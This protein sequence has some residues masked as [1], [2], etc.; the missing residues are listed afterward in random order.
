MAFFTQAY[1]DF[2]TELAANNHKDWFDVNRHRYELHVKKPLYAFIN[3]LI[4]TLARSNPSFLELQAKDCIFR[5]NRDIRF[6]SDKT[7]YKLRCSAVLAPNGKKGMLGEGFYIELGPEHL[8]LYGGVYELDKDQL[9]NFRLALLENLEVFQQAY[10]HPDFKQ[11]FG[12][13]Q[14]AK[15]KI[16]PKD[17]K[18]YI[19][20][21]PLLL[22]KQFYYYTTFSP[23]MILDDR[24]D[25]ILLNAYETAK[26]L[27][28]LFTQML[29]QNE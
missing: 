23:E 1:L 21:E 13:I 28:L 4:A 10:T 7:P 19:A 14:G 8:R 18:E 24:L 15:N 16:L 6:S 9:L 5:I 2:F 27:E 3:H 29:S 17:L 11:T 12:E 25:D 22:N 20:Q 26:P